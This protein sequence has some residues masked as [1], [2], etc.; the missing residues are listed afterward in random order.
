M[1]PERWERLEDL[2]SQALELPPNQREDFLRTQC[3]GDQNLRTEVASLID[4][5]ERAPESPSPLAAVRE[6]LAALETEYYLGRNLGG[7]QLEEFLGRGGTSTVYRARDMDSG[8]AVAVKIFAAHE[9]PPQDTGS[10]EVEHPNVAKILGFASDSG[11]PYMVLEYVEGETVA[12]RL[13]RSPLTQRELIPIARQ[14]ASGLAEAHRRG[15]CHGD[16]KPANLMIDK[17][18]IVKILDLGSAGG[19]AAYMAPER[20][21]GKPPDARSDVYSFGATLYEMAAGE[22]DFRMPAHARI[23]APLGAVIERCMDKDPE[24]RYP[25][26]G[27]LAAALDRLKPPSRLH[28]L[29]SRIRWRPILATGA[30]AALAAGIAWFGYAS[31]DAPPRFQLLTEDTNLA[32]GPALSPDGKLLAYAANR[33]GE[34]GLDIWVQTV[35]AGTPL[36]LTAHEEDDFTPTFSPDGKWIVFASERDGGGLYRVA[37]KGG[38]QERIGPA[39]SR[40][41]FSPDGKWIIYSTGPRGPRDRRAYRPRSI[42][43]LPAAGGAPRPFHAEFSSAHSPVW[44]PDGRRVLF[45]GHIREDET[46]TWWIGMLDGSAPKPVRA[47]T[48]EPAGGFAF[49]QN[50]ML[51]QCWL[52]DGRIVFQSHE[53]V[54]ISLM[55]APFSPQRSRFTGIPRRLTAGSEL[56]VDPACGPQGEIVYAS[57]RRSAD[58]WSVSLG[59]ANP[60]HPVTHSRRLATFPSLS[61]DGKKLLYATFGTTRSSAWLRDLESGYEHAIEGLHPLGLWLRQSADGSRIASLE[62]RDQ[63]G[64][65]RIEDIRGAL[66]QAFPEVRLPLDF[67]RDGRFVLAGSGGNPPAILL[68]R[69]GAGRGTPLLRH[70]T[71]KLRHARF[72]PD[73]RSIAFSAQQAEEPHRTFLARFQD[74]G[75]IPLTAWTPATAVSAGNAEWSPDGRR[76]YFISEQDG[77]P[78]LWEQ[79][80][81]GGSNRPLGGARAIRHFHHM[82][83]NLWV[84]SASKLSLAAARDK[85]V[86]TLVSSTSGIWMAR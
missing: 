31:R 19:T 5:Q 70:P 23:P 73:Q 50:S 24:S 74:G 13:R 48:P 39:G 81:D 37:V 3:G 6:V 40:P 32:L 61:P 76:L 2:L 7:Y 59:A 54:H 77:Y 78:C 64:T 52:A 38:V 29:G 56:S 16:L 80:L 36:R 82:A 44:S 15:I 51:P 18:G 53:G 42:Y 43:L 67:S 8:H 30:A 75:E 17:R 71:M 20:A 1:T 4:A 49:N 57:M 28:A 14:I 83:L 34:E 41:R 72:S 33:D 79:R 62:D 69:A 27:A 12:Q 9:I 45:S 85:V 84:L 10:A 86:L 47:P 35:P 46:D 21:A 68:H 63:G 26:A 65:L 11:I 58:L 66:V 60:L 25:D 55:A 22:R